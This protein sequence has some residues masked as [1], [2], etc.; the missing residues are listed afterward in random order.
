MN[1]DLT[2]KKAPP[3]QRKI[4]IEMSG[5]EEALV[6]ILSERGETGIDE[7]CLSSG[8]SM[9]TI[10]AAL[11]NLEFEGIVKSLP[12]KLYDLR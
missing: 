11:L 9:S 7:L 12:G 6:N 10:S 4:F 2:K 1:W 5:E 3:A 8:F